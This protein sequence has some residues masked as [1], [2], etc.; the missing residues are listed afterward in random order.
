V[1]PLPEKAAS[2]LGGLPGRDMVST[3]AFDLAVQA[4]SEHMLPRA[5]QL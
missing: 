4:M 3:C 5:V 2:L 1:T